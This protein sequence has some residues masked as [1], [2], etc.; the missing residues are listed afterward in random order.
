VAGGTHKW[1]ENSTNV[2]ASACYKHS[3]CYPQYV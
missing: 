3:H 2:T 1:D